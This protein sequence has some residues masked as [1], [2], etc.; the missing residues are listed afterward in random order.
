[1]LSPGGYGLIP[2]VDANP[3]EL[4]SFTCGRD[5]LDQF[6]FEEA[7]DFHTSRLGFTSLVFHKDFEGLVGYFTLANDAL[8]LETSENYSLGLAMDLTLSAFPATKIGKFAVRSELQRKGV[9]RA[10]MDLLVGESLDSGGLSA[11][12]LLVTDAVNEGDI[13]A[14]YDKCGFLESLWAKK[15]RLN[16]GRGKTRTQPQTIKMYLDVFAWLRGHVD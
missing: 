15:Q 6:L 2:V 8:V 11:S 16:H 3:S 14:F 10:M 13:I 5:G 7:N 4:T 12:R 9:G 1:M